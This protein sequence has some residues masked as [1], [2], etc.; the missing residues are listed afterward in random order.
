MAQYAR[1]KVDLKNLIKFENVLKSD[2][3]GNGMGPIRLAMRR[4]AYRFFVFALRRFKR[5]SRG[6]GDWPPL[7]PGTIARRRSGK[8]KKNPMILINTGIMQGALDPQIA[9]KPGKLDEDIPFGVRV[10]F[11]GPVK[12]AG[13]KTTIATIANWHQA[14]AGNLPERKVIDEPDQQTLSA[15]A[16]DM[17][18]ALAMMGKR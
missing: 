10:G 8:G 4:W 5:F 1:V 3:K 6:G 11:G 16:R 14:G 9:Q 12:H 2:L 7:S 18:K 17:V 15:M 13:G